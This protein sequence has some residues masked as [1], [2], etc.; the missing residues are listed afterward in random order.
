M[1]VKTATK[2]EYARDGRKKKKRERKKQ[3]RSCVCLRLTDATQTST[4]IPGTRRS[5][6]GF[7]LARHLGEEPW[8]SW[9]FCWISLISVLVASCDWCAG[10]IPCC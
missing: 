8:S 10:R 2:I 6:R 9:F 1:R 5:Q 7:D 4:G 3:K